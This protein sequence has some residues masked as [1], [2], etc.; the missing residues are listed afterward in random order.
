[1]KVLMADDHWVFRAGLK[2]LMKRL[3]DQVTV[4]EAGN[5][6]EAIA[7]TKENPDLDLILL[8][9][10]MP[11]SEPFSGLRA[12]HEAA[13]K[14][15]I[16]VLSVVENRSD[17]IHAIEL[18][19]MGYVTKAATGDEILKAVNHVLSGD[20]FI[21][22][23]LLDKG[24][25]PYAPCGPASRRQGDVRGLIDTL[26]QR[27][28]EVFRLLAQGKSNPEI[29]R[30]LGVSAHTVRIHISAI[31]RVLGVTNRTQAAV[32]AVNHYNEQ[33]RSEAAQMRA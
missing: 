26:T 6:Q 1:M 7:L 4:L 15:P 32:F 27:Q 21:P 23:S 3:D 30:E 9:L 25:E 31:L 14:V 10:L 13:P 16:V 17:V 22:R 11:G 18:G 33:Q 2:H 28:R 12:L 5:L 29:A 8:D 24:A 20:V 19:A